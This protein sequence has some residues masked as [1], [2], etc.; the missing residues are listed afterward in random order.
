MLPNMSAAS[1]TLG[2][3]SSSGSRPDTG[4]IAF[5]NRASLLVTKSSLNAFLKRVQTAFSSYF[6]ETP[7]NSFDAA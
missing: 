5:K 3:V 2:A 6:I 1:N 7:T 4:Q